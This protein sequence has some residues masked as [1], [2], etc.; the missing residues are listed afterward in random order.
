[1]LSLTHKNQFRRGN[2]FRPQMHPQDG[3]TLFVQGKLDMCSPPASQPTSA[4]WYPEATPVLLFLLDPS[5]S[6]LTNMSSKTSSFT[7]WEGESLR[8]TCCKVELCCTRRKLHKLLFL[9]S[10]SVFGTCSNG[11]W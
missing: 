9:M 7:V 4:P 11:H 5:R 8:C 6:L 2:P 1:M 10:I 3:R